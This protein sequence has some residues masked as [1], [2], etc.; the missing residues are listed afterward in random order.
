MDKKLTISEVI[1]TIRDKNKKEVKKE[2]ERLNTITN[3]KRSYL[4]QN[5]IFSNKPLL[6]IKKIYYKKEIVRR[7]NNLKDSDIIFLNE[8]Y[9]SFEERELNKDKALKK[10]LN[11]YFGRINNINKSILSNYYYLSEHLNLK[12]DLKLRRIYPVSDGYFSRVVSKETRERFK[13][14]KIYKLSDLENRLVRLNQFEYSNICRYLEDLNDFYLDD[15]LFISL[16]NKSERDLFDMYLEEESYVKLSTK[17]NY[18]TTELRAR[19]YTIIKKLLLFFDTYE[20]IRALDMIFSFDDCKVS[21]SKLK[22]LF[23]LYYKYFVY[24]VKNKYIYKTEFINNLDII[25]I[26]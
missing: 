15:V 7:L 16:L 1:F 10:R 11:K 20:G 19:I 17:F 23:P 24:L 4:Y 18:S 13:E 5:D 8:V 14:L 2:F 26:K 3:G 12:K 21:V 6:D 9:N 25:V 22:E